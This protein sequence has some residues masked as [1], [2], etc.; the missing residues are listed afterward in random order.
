MLHIDRAGKVFYCPL[1]CNRQV[2]DSRG[3]SP[4]QAVADLEWLGDEMLR[5]KWVKLHGFP[6]DK[7]V[8]AVFTQ[9]LEKVKL[10]EIGV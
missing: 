6:K 9:P 7:K 5:G 1:K 2:D 3:E 4:Y 10:A 8:M